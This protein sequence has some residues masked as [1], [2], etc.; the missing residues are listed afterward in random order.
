MTAVGLC[1]ARPVRQ[2]E[3]AQS[4]C[5]RE[6]GQRFSV[7]Q[8]KEVNIL[9]SFGKADDRH[10]RTLLQPVNGC[11]GNPARLVWIC[12]FLALMKRGVIDALWL[13]YNMELTEINF[14]SDNGRRWKLLQ[15]NQALV[16]QRYSIICSV[17]RLVRS[18]RSKGFLC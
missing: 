10:A 5:Q 18:F 6:P 7:S 2:A 13:S 15:K 12:A 17:F 11:F 16:S 14:Q 1:S 4:D 3:R 9:G 8:R